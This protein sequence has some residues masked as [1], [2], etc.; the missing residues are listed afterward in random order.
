MLLTKVLSILLL[1]NSQD[2]ALN[3]LL[4]SNDKIYVVVAV[5]SIIFAGIV[6]YLTVLDKKLSHLEKMLKEKTKSE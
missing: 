4:R 2:S 6:I 5:L 3:E 1:M